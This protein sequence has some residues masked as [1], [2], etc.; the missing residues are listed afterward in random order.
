MILLGEKM[1]VQGV[2]DV[3]IVPSLEMKLGTIDSIEVRTF[4]AQ[5]PFCLR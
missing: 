5:R 3:I 2:L 1:F 4:S